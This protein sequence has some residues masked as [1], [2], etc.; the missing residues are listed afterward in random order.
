[1]PLIQ[2]G[3]DLPANSPRLSRGNREGRYPAAISH[4]LSLPPK[5]QVV[6]VDEVLQWRDVAPQAE[7]END[8]ILL[9]MS[10]G[11]GTTCFTGQ[12]QRAFLRLERSRELLE[13]SITI[14]M[15]AIFM[16][17]PMLEAYENRTDR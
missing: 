15:A 13:Y 5:K 9:L 14:L 6:T 7:N 3:R 10:A 16:S 1:M 12:V 11:P 2:T 8:L 4:I 17:A